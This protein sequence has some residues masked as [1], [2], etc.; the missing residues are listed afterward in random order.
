MKLVR[1]GCGCVGT[2]DAETL[3]KSC[4]GDL[5]HELTLIHP[6]YILKRNKPGIPL[7][8]EET[9]QVVNEIQSLI[10]DGYK[11]RRVKGILGE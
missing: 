4:G 5:E 6:D 8:K 11:F 10:L 3:L 7:T 2:D 1:F 9:N